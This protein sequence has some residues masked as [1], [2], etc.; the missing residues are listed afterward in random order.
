MKT[1]KEK[2]IS[3]EMYDATDGELFKQRTACRL[4]LNELNASLAH[5]D[6]K[7]KELI[8]RLLQRESE[9]VCIQPPF[10]CDYGFNI[11]FGKNVFLNFNCVILDCAKVN[12]G[13]NTFI[14]PNVQIYTPLHP[15]DSKE[16]KTWLE[17]AK[18]VSIGNDCWIGGSVIILPGV[19]IGDNCVIG[20][21]SVVTKDIPSNSVAFGN[22]AKVKNSDKH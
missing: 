1:E 17:Y 5:E 6:S 21:G 9:D 19:K 11:N 22:P 8:D 16:R 20:A 14:G 2:M 15:M 13:D 12:I 4:I 10:Y 7:R 3:G 18:E